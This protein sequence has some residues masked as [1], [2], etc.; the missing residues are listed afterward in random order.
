MKPFFHYIDLHCHPSL[1]PF[2]KSFNKLPVGR[3]NARKNSNKNLWHYD[4][5]TGMDKLLNITTGLTKFSQSNFTSLYKGKVR[6]VCVSLYPL[7]KGFLENN[8]KKEFLVDIASNF[9]LGVGKKRIDHIQN[10][11]NYYED[12]KKQYDF[13]NQQDGKVYRLPEGMCRY[14][15][16]ANFDEIETI[17]KNESKLPN[18]ETIFVVLSIEG[19]HVL[20][21]GLG[22]TPDEKEV[23]RNL[24]EIKK[25]RYPPFFITVAHHFWN[26]IC[27]HAPS[28][29][30]IVLKFTD[31]QEGIGEGFTPLGLKV[32]NLLLDDTKGK[33]ILPDI[34]HMSIQARR[35]YYDLLDKDAYKD[36]PIIASHAA[37]N[38]L[39]SFDNPIPGD[40]NTTDKLNPVA[41]NLYN[42]EILRISKSKGIIGLQLDERR[43]VNKRTRKKIKN[44]LYRNKIMHYRSELLWYQIQHIAELLDQNGLF[45]WDCMGIGSDFDGIIDSLN[46]FWTAEELPYLADFIERHAYNFTSKK[47]L[48]Q[49][50]N[51]IDADEIVNRIMGQNAYQFL[52]ENF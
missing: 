1:K 44:S 34:K 46:G 40:T 49:E 35:E 17:R 13:Y 8:I 6:I 37:C 52:K 15:M 36:V 5:P 14:K 39:I 20:N 23:I 2:G 21:I 3:Q 43:I 19:L 45:A 32:L 12:L 26:H 27:G 16:V 48:K 50:R 51:R 7:E 25:W 41:I 30:G 42:D 9:A 10:M 22:R 38:G 11:P 31:Q 18:T 24:K 28:L 4:P 29:S 33:R 47:S